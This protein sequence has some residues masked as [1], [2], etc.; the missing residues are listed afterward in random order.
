MQLMID[1]LAESAVALRMAARFLEEHAQLREI[2]EAQAMQTPG[3][4]GEEDTTAAPPPPPIHDH[5]AAQ[6]PPP[7]PPPPA[8]TPTAPPAPPAAM[9]PA[10]VPPVAPVAAIAPL[11]PTIPAAG[12]VSNEFDK[13]GVPFDERIHQK[14]RKQKA[15]GTWKIKK[16]LDPAIVEA[17]MRELAPHIRGAGTPATAGAIAP[18]PLPQ[19]PPPPQAS[20]PFPPPPPLP[21]EVQAQ[22]LAASQAPPLDPYR[23]FVKKITDARGHNRLTAEEV[24][25]AVTQAGAPSLQLLNNMPHLLPLV[26]SYIDAILATR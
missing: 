11:P 16:G 25:Q 2:S 15:D 21:P 26:E 13:S 8:V 3:N 4:Y 20:I 24:I 9:A 10:F 23:T 22:A 12:P 1:L 18:V 5:A 7:P 17:V 14:S 6:V 19:A